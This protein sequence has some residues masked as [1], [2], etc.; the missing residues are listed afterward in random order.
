[1]AEKILTYFKTQ[2]SF[3]WAIALL[4]LYGFLAVSASTEKCATFDEI[5]HLTA[6]YSY[7]TR[8][9][10]RLHPENGIF[11]QYWAALPLLKDAVKFPSDQTPA[12]RNAEV[13]NVGHEFFYNLGNDLNS[14]LLQSRCMIALL[15]M[16]LG[17]IVFLWSKELWGNKAAL[18]SLFLFA[19]S[20]T[21]LAHGALATSDMA[22]TFCLIVGTW[23]FWK[24][25]H[26]ISWIWLVV[27][28][29][30]FVLALLSKATGILLIP[31]ALVL[32]VIR[33][34]SRCPLTSSLFPL[35]KTDSLKSRFWVLTA[36]LIIHFLFGALAIWAAYHF[37]FKASAEA[38]PFFASWE[39][40]NN[41]DSLKEQIIANLH[42]MK[43]LPEAFLYGL[44]YVFKFADHR[45]AFLNEEIYL[46]GKWYF[47]PL[48]FFYKTPLSLFL[49][50]SAACAV[51][52]KNRRSSPEIF[53]RLLPMAALCVI[54]GFVCLT[55]RLNLGHRHIL[56]LYPVLFI[57]AGASVN[58]V[59]WAKDWPRLII[60]ILAG[61][62]A[63]ESFLI[64]PHYLAYF[65]QWAGGPARGYQRLVDSSL[66][67]GQDLIGLKKWL[68]KNAGKQPVYLAY[69]GTGSPEFYG[70]QSIRMPGFFDRRPQQM[71]PMNSGIYCVS[72]TLLQG[73]YQ[74]VF[75]HWN[76]ARDQAY[77]KA[78]DDFKLF[79]STNGDP[80]KRKKLIEERGE[81]FW[82][83]AWQEF[84]ALRFARLCSFL[85]YQKPDT[86]I[87]YSILI[88]R[89]DE[90]K[91][92]RALLDPSFEIF[93]DGLKQTSLG[94]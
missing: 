64:R 26:E 82:A 63:I 68:D 51:L 94:D 13:F 32:S 24:L 17:A 70:I 58:I 9:D 52:W 11:P 69:F 33:I 28:L 85:R 23:S 36:L 89:L 6:G 5:A 66:D 83:R 10:F 73:L 40:L 19:L 72:A 62:F 50:L 76:V 93:S 65:N 20:P 86:Q 49:L 38:L 25:L 18:L 47:F 60:F 56:P 41:G 30:S 34:F 54:Y 59:A 92:K 29:L 90:K 87:G 45:M 78:L 3:L 42:R 77:F 55:A 53:Y 61:W 79:D 43:L 12:W 31:I 88:Y 27:S 37:R 14:M 57:L 21:M 84:E 16:A 81:S 75:G 15:G 1:M 7:W 35:P 71:Y 48:A 67:W 74:P 39:F 44:A 8:N 4:L 80:K 46:G 22:L 91:L 2:K